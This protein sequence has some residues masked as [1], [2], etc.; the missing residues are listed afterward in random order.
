[1]AELNAHIK[2]ALAQ[3]QLHGANWEP[4]TALKEGPKLPE[5]HCVSCG[6]Q[7]VGVTANCELRVWGQS[8]HPLKSAHS[9][10]GG[11]VIP[12]VLCKDCGSPLAR[13]DLVCPCASRR[14]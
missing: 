8:A 12:P 9:A 7:C 6:G 14:R 1:M 10:L 3:V 5:G 11:I 2:W 4:I 13:L